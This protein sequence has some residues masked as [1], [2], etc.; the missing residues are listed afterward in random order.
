MSVVTESAPFVPAAASRT[1][2]IVYAVRNIVAEAKKLEARGREVLYLNIGDPVLFDLRPPKPL[3]AAHQKALKD[4]SGYTASAG[5]PESREAIAEWLRKDG[6]PVSA[7]D[8]VISYGASEAIDL[9]L[10]A[11]L[12][13]GDELMVPMPGYPL[14]EAVCAKLG[15]KTS[16]YRLEPKRGWQ[17]DV[18]ALEKAWSPRAKALLLISPGNPTGGVLSEDSIRALAEFAAERRMV[19][20]ADEVYR[21][22]AFDPIPPRAATLA[23]KGTPVVSF[24]SLSKSHLVPGWRCGWGSFLHCGQP[25]RAAV[26]RLADARLCAPSGAQRTI[27]T[28]LTDLRH[29]PAVRRKM[30]QRL[31]LVERKLAATKKFQIVRGGAAFYSFFRV[32]QTGPGGDTGWVLRLLEETGVLV[33]PGSG[34]GMPPE[35][36]W[37]RM[38]TTAPPEVLEEACDKIAAFVSK[39]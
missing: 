16:A 7:D 1:A 29:I 34:F 15:A 39:G 38:V 28:A 31:R 27:P 11:L 12:E 21:E 6:I 19:L 23:P 35:D 33:V 26:Q 4:G 10:T 22:L 8:V 37:V 5:V 32:K 24:D 14:Y 30:K 18:A 17:P 2:G 25:L 3:V 36:G 9:V 13:P 20:L